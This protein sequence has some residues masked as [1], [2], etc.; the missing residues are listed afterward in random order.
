MQVPSKVIFN[1]STYELYFLNF[2]LCYRN[3]CNLSILSNVGSRFCKN[4][5][6]RRSPPLLIE[7][8]IIT[9]FNIFLKKSFLLYKICVKV[10]RSSVFV[11]TIHYIAGSTKLHAKVSSWSAK[12]SC[13]CFQSLYHFLS[14]FQICQ[15]SRYWICSLWTLWL[16]SVLYDCF[17]TNFPVQISTFVLGIHPKSKA[18]LDLN[19][20]YVLFSW[21]H[22]I[23]QFTREI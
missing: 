7:T 21:W 20:Q 10:K 14:V 11:K 17:C 18:Q 22:T 23:L 12:T 5:Y 2:E 1:F 3:I 9:Y 6:K 15:N 13:W 4:S 19:C 8:I 16:I